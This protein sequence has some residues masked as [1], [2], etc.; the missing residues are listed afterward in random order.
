MCLSWTGRLCPDSL[1][2]ARKLGSQLSVMKD[3]GITSWRLVTLATP[4]P[5]WFICACYAGLDL[6]TQ[7]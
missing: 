7:F 6:R 2:S 1:S 3:Q 5:R 4:T